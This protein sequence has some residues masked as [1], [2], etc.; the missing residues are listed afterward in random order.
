M[1]S[2]ALQ[3]IKENIQKHERG[4]DASFLDLG[5]CGMEIKYLKNRVYEPID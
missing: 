1:S 4:E 3:R 2:L 5:A